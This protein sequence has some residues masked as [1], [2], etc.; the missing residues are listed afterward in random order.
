MIRINKGASPKVLTR[1][2]AKYDLKNNALYLA[3]PG[4][5]DT[6]GKTFLFPEAYKSK[7]VKKALFAAQFGKCA[8][9][10]AKFVSDDAHVEHFRP[11]GRVD[12]WP[13]GPSSYPG[14]YW[15]AYDWSNLFLCKSIIN[16]SVKRNFFPLIG[17]VLRNRNHLDIRIETSVLINPGTENPRIHIRFE[18]EEIKGITTRGK[19]T[20]DLLDL[21]NGQ[22]DEARRSRYRLLKGF[23]MAVE[24]FF[25]KGIPID[26][27]KVAGLIETL[28]EA[29]MPSA[30]FSSMAIDLLTG[31]PHIE[32][33][34]D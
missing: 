12:T 2:K 34:Q 7:S 23:K 29:R 18:G 22:L 25:E 8:F 30:E 17:P 24:L 16:S 1:A 26:H 15:L 10:E 31:W 6:G 13:T 32:S 19:Q 14:Y 5:Y 27:P 4:H 28:K 20:I 11:K 9:S 21:R 3:A 33:V